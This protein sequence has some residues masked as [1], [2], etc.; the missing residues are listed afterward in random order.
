MHGAVLVTQSTPTMPAR[1]SVGGAIW[2]FK[3]LRFD[4]A[5]APSFFFFR[6]VPTFRASPSKGIVISTRR[7]CSPRISYSVNTGVFLFR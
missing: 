3:L 4:A 2:M 5:V 7:V 1:R 6:S